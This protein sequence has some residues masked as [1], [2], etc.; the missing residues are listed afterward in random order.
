[1][2][3]IK[4]LFYYNKEDKMAPDRK[5]EYAEYNRKRRDDPDRLAKH[6]QQQAEWRRNKYENDPEFKEKVKE[7]ARQYQAKLREQRQQARLEMVA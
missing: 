1:M 3:D 2:F 7:R 5:A 6:R 4:K